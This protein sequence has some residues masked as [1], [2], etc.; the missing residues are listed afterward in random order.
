M[1]VYNRIYVGGDI[2]MN[3]E[4]HGDKYRLV[5]VQLCFHM[6]K[7]DITWKNKERERKKTIFANVKADLW[8][9]FITYY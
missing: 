6:M 9:L 7:N 8:W 1:D 5:M 3:K 2:Q 4:I